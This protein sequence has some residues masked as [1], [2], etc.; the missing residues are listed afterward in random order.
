MA[1]DKRYKIR[2]EVVTPLHIGTG[3]EGGWVQGVDYAQKDGKVYVI[4][5]KQAVRK[6]I[7]I[8]NLYIPDERGRIKGI[9]DIDSRRLESVSRYIFQSP[10]STTNDIKVFIRSQFNDTPVIAGSSIKGAVRSALFK[11]LGNDYLKKQ[12]EV[13]GMPSNEKALVKEI[14][15]DMNKGT[16]FMRFIRIT[17]F[18]I[19][20]PRIA[21]NLPGT[22]LV[23][24]KLFNLHNNEQDRK[25][26]G[27]WKQERNLTDRTFRV[28][29]FNTL[30]EC[31]EP[32]KTGEGAIIFSR[33]ALDLLNKSEA[34][35]KYSD[36]KS[37][38][39]NDEIN[40]LFKTINDTTR[41]YL[42]KELAFFRQ[43]D[44]AE[45]TESII[46]SIEQVLKLIPPRGSDTGHFCLLKMS[47][48][49]GFHAITGDWIYDS[50][51]DTGV[52]NGKLNKKSRKIAL[53]RG[54]KSQA[55]LTG[56]ELMGLV[57][58]QV[59]SDKD[60]EYEKLVNE[61]QAL[62]RN[63]NWKEA[64]EK[65]EKAKLKCPHRKEHKDI[66]AQC[67]AIKQKEDEKAEQQRRQTSYD[68]LIRQA[69]ELINDRRWN[70]ARQKAAS[71]EKLGLS[72][73][74]HIRVTEECEKAIKFSKP[75]SEVVKTGMSL[76]NIIGTTRT[77]LNYHQFGEQEYA[78]LRDCL[79][80]TK[81][82]EFRKKAGELRKA[83]GENWTEKLS[84]ELYPPKETVKES[85]TAV[86]KADTVEVDKQPMGKH[87]SSMYALMETK[88]PEG[89]TPHAPLPKDEERL[90]EKLVAEEESCSKIVRWLKR[91]FK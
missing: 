11:H 86:Q 1:T 48:G 39:V 80:G 34:N 81:E 15:G 41:A 88:Q 21:P 58:L 55:V 7:D 50:Y 59:V 89:A 40:T 90:E 5:I 17:D 60:I 35:V 69:H 72:R 13:K 30:Y 6:G 32:G 8:A 10:E 4:D 91:L 82:K 42:E 24:T 22:I 29:R 67:E 62:L 64:L 71:A 36:E 12:R 47:A 46:E 18:D 45:N 51:T 73:T 43:Y 54:D 9:N 57:K 31:I 20:R 14:F 38:L 52:T 75:L 77:W 2:L 3:A 61:A 66:L 83:V 19:P 63:N 44:E 37:R 76:G 33:S 87:A 25:W 68:T 28:N 27:G 85:K 26:H 53:H 78:V 16:D 74:E 65:I 70:E 84:R 49:V 56:F 79:K 23:N